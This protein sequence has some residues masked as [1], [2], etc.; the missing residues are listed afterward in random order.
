QAVEQR[1]LPGAVG[2]DQRRDPAGRNLKR[3]VVDGEQATEALDDGVGFEERHSWLASSST[4]SANSLGTRSGPAPLRLPLAAA[5]V[6]SPLPFSAT[7]CWAS[8]NRSSSTLGVRSQSARFWTMPM[9]EPPG[10]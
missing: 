7:S 6:P 10:R 8:A 1:G 3:D 2:P 9:I 5:G 4:F